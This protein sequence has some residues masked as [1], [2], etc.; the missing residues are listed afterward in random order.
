MTKS[1]LNSSVEVGDITPVRLSSEKDTIPILL[2]L[3]LINFQ[4]YFFLKNITQF[5]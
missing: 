1:H 4:E 2:Y 5:C 3:C